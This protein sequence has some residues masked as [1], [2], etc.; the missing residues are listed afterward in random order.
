MHRS[1]SL[2]YYNH[3]VALGNSGFKILHGHV[4]ENHIRC[5]L[6]AMGKIFISLS[7]QFVKNV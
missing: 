6:A 2:V 4:V 3:S 5:S 7:G 1:L